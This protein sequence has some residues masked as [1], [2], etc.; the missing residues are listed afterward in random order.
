MI[1]FGGH[2]TIC[3]SAKLFPRPDTLPWLV[4][5]EIYA[6]RRAY[7][8]HISCKSPLLDFVRASPPMAST[9]MQFNQTAMKRIDRNSPCCTTVCSMPRQLQL[10]ILFREPYEIPPEDSDGSELRRR[11]SQ[12]FKFRLTRRSHCR[13]NLHRIVLSR[14]EPSM[15]DF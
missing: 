10:L 15:N 12:E 2:G 13:L 1:N 5:R 9:L 11:L 8:V 14:L 3:F 4:F 6:Q 7:F